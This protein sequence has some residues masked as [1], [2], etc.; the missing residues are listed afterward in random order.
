MSPHDLAP[1]TG[2]SALIIPGQCHGSDGLMELDSAIG[3]KS[4]KKER[5]GQHDSP[6][7]IDV[8]I[9]TMGEEMASHASGPAVQR[10]FMS[11]WLRG[12]A[13]LLAGLAAGIGGTFLVLHWYENVHRCIAVS[14]AFVSGEAISLTSSVEGRIGSIFV[15]EGERISAGQV[16]AR[17]QDEDCQAK[18][19]NAQTNVRKAENQLKKIETGL[20]EL[21]QRVPQELNQAKE[22]LTASRFRLKAAERSLRQQSSDSDRTHIVYRGGPAYLAKKE[23]AAYSRRQAKAELEAARKD[24]ERNELRHQT[25]R[26]K[27]NL[28]DTKTRFAAAARKRLD[29]ARSALDTASR[30]LAATTISSPITGIVARKGYA[31]GEPVK[32]GDAVAV[33]VDLERL[34]VEALVE[35]TAARNVVVGQSAD[36]RLESCPQKTFRGRVAKVGRAVEA[37]ADDPRNDRR[38]YENAN[39]SASKVPVRIEFAQPEPDLRPGMK[40]SVIIDTWTG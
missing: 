11:K 5:K 8:P 28:L 1:A 32:P 2:P 38:S 6:E 18:V 36:I 30:G 17:L 24:L 20:V 25:I 21:R 19:I 9:E 14:D 23:D 35:E 10:E 26:A 40:A 39:V 29:E 13:I 7:S 33:V 37:P 4:L 12:A 16:V 22:A 27:K 34:W 15:E 31:G 3:G